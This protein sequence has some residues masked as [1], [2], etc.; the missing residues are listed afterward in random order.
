M[1]FAASVVTVDLRHEFIDGGK[2]D[3]THADRISI[4]HRFA[5]AFGFSV[6]SVSTIAATI[7]SA[8]AWVS[9][10]HSK[11]KTTSSF[12]LEQSAGVFW[13]CYPMVFRFAL[14]LAGLQ[15][16]LWGGL[17]THPKMGRTGENSGLKKPSE[18]RARPVTETLTQ[19]VANYAFSISGCG[20]SFAI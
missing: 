19:T 1:S 5:N 10:I 9:P 3:K 8:C 6:T 20:G 16:V 13:L 17:Y 7:R 15:I 18:R 14:R 4:F 11:T 12:S 2:S